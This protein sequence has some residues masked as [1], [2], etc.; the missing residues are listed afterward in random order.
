MGLREELEKLKFDTRLVDLNLK[1]KRVKPEELQ[2][3]LDALPDTAA[4]VISLDALEDHGGHT[5]GHTEFQTLH[6]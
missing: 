1:H 5:N 6:S 3:H 2:K 4:N